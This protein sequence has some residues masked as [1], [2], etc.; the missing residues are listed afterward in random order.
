VAGQQRHNQIQESKQAHKL[1]WAEMMLPHLYQDVE[2]ALRLASR[3]ESHSTT[4][5]AQQSSRLIKTAWWREGARLRALRQVNRS[6]LSSAIALD[7]TLY[8]TLKLTS[9]EAGRRTLVV[10]LITAWLG[11]VWWVHWRSR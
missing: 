10:T 11:R 7:Y 8:E 5:W 9:R 1:R 4:D 2:S 3:S 6:G